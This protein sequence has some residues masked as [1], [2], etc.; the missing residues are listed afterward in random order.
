[1]IYYDTKVFRSTK[2]A[3]EDKKPYIIHQGGTSSGK[4]FNILLALFNHCIQ[5]DKEFL[6][7]IV[8]ETFPV[9]KK[10]AI[11]DFDTILNLLNYDGNKNK[12]DFTYKIGKSTFEFFAVDNPGKAKSG[13]RH[14][15]FINE[16]NEVDYEIVY[17]LSWR[18][19]HTVIFDYNPSHEFWFHTEF[20]PTKDRSEYI[21]KISTYKDN[22]ALDEKIIKD[23]ESLPPDLYRIYGEGKLGQV[24][25]LIFDNWEIVDEFPQNAKHVTYGLDFGFD[26][27][28]T[29]LVMIG[30]YDSCI[31]VQ[32]L[33]YEK[34]L[35]TDDIDN[36]MSTL[37]ISK[38]ITIY[39][40]SSEPRLVTELWDRGWYI[41]KV[42]K[43]S[44]KAS[45]MKLKRFNIRVTR[46]STNLIKEFKNYKWKEKDGK[47]IG[48]PI[49]MYNHGIDALR[50]GTIDLRV[51][52]A[53][54]VL[55]W[56]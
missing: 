51:N 37:G 15:L 29:A 43:D 48:V 21:F 12:S 5:S 25:G 36:I 35:T 13:K 49:D 11:R 55:G 39:A 50:Y 18:T 19:R 2:A 20:L 34:S 41:Q 17:Q 32:E 42:V 8:A 3:L 6:V 26:P 40:D 47:S 53:V 54:D 16:C 30:I 27:D 31:Y 23:I 14:Y 9:L 28:P 1:M 45:I 10:G 4:T 38:T 56:A 44:V 22:P 52:S 33:I 24:K 46:D 7:S